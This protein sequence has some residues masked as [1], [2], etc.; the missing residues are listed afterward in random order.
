MP[1]TDQIAEYQDRH[2]QFRRFCWTFHRAQYRAFDQVRHQQPTRLGYRA[3]LEHAV[4]CSAVFRQTEVLP[5]HR[6]RQRRRQQLRCASQ[7][8]SQPMQP[9]GHAERLRV[10][11]R[12][13]VYIPKVFNGKSKL[14][15]FFSCRG[16]RLASRPDRAKSPI[17]SPPCRSG[18]GNFSDLL[19][20]NSKY[21]IYDPLSVARRSGP[22]RALYPDAHAGEHHS[23]K[24]NSQSQDLR[25]VHHAGSRLPTASGQCG[26]RSRSTTSWPW[27]R[28][29]TST[30]PAWPAGETDAPDQKNRFS[31]SWNWSH[32][33]EN[34]QDWTYAS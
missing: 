7:L 26:A 17:R 9:G 13:T 4:E 20:I 2:D 23:P 19:N 30:T 25:L 6:R 14:F 31:F 33:I 27:D 18:Q 32:F 11:P 3:I 28:P 15:W 34:A 16:T 24:Q 10:H 1:F 12:R 8:R 29:T 5:E 21:Q 22:A